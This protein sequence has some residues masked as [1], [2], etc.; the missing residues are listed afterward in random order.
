MSNQVDKE[1]VA[2]KLTEWRQSL[3]L[4]AADLKSSFY[5]KPN[6]NQLFRQHC[7]LV[8]GT[9][10]EVWR[11][12]GL[13]KDA[14]LIAVG[15]YGRSELYPH[16]DID[17]LILLHPTS[18]ILRTDANHLINSKIETLISLIWDLGLHV[19]HSVRTLEECITEAHKDITVQTNIMES[20][21]LAGE[22]LHYSEFLHRVKNTLNIAEFMEEKL[23]E[24]E[25]R[26][27]KY[28]DTAYNLEPNIKENPGG[29][30][31]LHIIGWLV[32]CAG[33]NQAQSLSSTW[34]ALVN[35]HFITAQEARKIRHHE[36][37]LQLLRIHLHFL[38]GRREDKLL[39]D[40]QRTLATALGFSNNKNKRASEQ[41]MQSYY[42]S[43]KFVRLMNEILLKLLQQTLLKTPSKVVEINAHFEST[44]HF[45]E[46]KTANLLQQYPSAIFEAFLLLQQHPNLKGMSARL[47]RNLHRV[48]HLVNRD[49]R[50]DQRNKQ[51]FIE[52]LS[53]PHG[54]NHALRAMNR[55]GIL[56]SYIPAF[57]KIIGQ[58]QHDLFHV[59][60]VDEHILNVLANLRRFSKPELKHEF[61]LCSQL[62]AEFDAPHLL[63]LAALFHDIAKGR[64]GDHS[65]LGTI[66]AL[67]FCKQ[68]DLPEPDAFFVAWL[69][70]A[71]LKMSA[72][73][74]KSDL[75]DPA[76][77]Q[78]FAQT[79]QTKRNLDA[80]YLLT[81]ADIRGTSPLVW[82]AWK[83]RLLEN[84]YQATVDALKDP[85]FHSKQIISNRIKEASTKLEGFDISKRSYEPLWQAF[86]DSYFIRHEG[87]EIAWQ[88]RLLIP[89]LYT[90][91]SIV[92]ARL[93]PHGDGIQ[94]M[95]YVRDRDDLFA[96]I[97]NF[98]DRMGYSIVEAK[99]YTTNHGYALN[100][101]IVLDSS[102]KSVSYSELL[103]SIETELANKLD[104]NLTLESPLQGRVSR[105]VKHMPIPTQVIISPHNNHHKLDIVANDRPGLLATLA[106]QLLKHG[107]ELHNAKIITL[108][109]RAEDTFLISARN[110]QRL[111]E[112]N[113]K[114]LQLALTN[115][116]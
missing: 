94:V 69:V 45:L 64:G 61:P 36:K 62:F 113:I 89:H 65:T 106:Q 63:Y 91:K 59:Y 105:Q 76:V 68:H 15:G 70:E 25:K 84:L 41:L 17:L 82:N 10:Q 9:L 34:H 71:H 6:A 18:D 44:N 107:I 98:F 28:N 97:C 43:F 60:T 114:S 72:T 90:Q 21:F 4:G 67:K 95:I 100:S 37:Q 2:Q 47:L 93:S 66:D 3:R 32:R 57:G 11:A 85:F 54:V 111:T 48:K 75:S 80:L 78:T 24:Q 56:G 42:R 19:G 115:K 31:D 33:L 26:H 51:Y 73:A 7:K 87:S 39:F 77:I 27:A 35:H 16:S 83:A 55:Y 92:R 40:F 79:V 109:N 46:A 14:T 50:K 112:S 22:K 13:N 74:Q 116:L 86:G 53:Q 58:M 110:N 88:S 30:R 20:R 81:V 5:A 101:F 49:F 103:K 8:D 38:S 102:G 29:L 52:I 104:E 23:K 108:G 96:R 12:L 1:A 99:I